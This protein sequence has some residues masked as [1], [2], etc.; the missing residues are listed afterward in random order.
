MQQM[1]F[2]DGLPITDYVHHGNKAS[3]QES[4]ISVS[5][6]GPLHPTHT[7]EKVDLV[8]VLLCFSK[9]V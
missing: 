2:Q 6:A 8:G 5:E 1:Y 3:K 7:V 4:I 9:S